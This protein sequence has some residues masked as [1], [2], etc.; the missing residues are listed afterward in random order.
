MLYCALLEQFREIPHSDGR[1]KITKAA[2]IE[3]QM[4]T[5]SITHGAQIPDIGNAEPSWLTA[6]WLQVSL[7]PIHSGAQMSVHNQCG[8]RLPHCPLTDHQRLMHQCLSERRVLKHEYTVAVTK[9][10]ICVC[11][12]KSGSVP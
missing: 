5:L 10:K 12:R 11:V 7:T 2:N 3:I 6:Y 9:E 1:S 4:S 8:T